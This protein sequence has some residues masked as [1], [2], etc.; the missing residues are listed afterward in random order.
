M[1]KLKAVS[2]LAALPSASIADRSIL[3][4]AAEVQDGVLA[5]AGDRAVGQRRV[6]EAVVAGAA[7]QRIA[8]PAAGE[9]VG[10]GHAPQGVGIGVS[11]QGVGEAE[12][13]TCSMPLSVSPAASPPETRPVARLTATPAAE[14]A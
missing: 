4:P 1:P 13:I 12:P 9:H 10:S 2:P 7:L 6:D 3:S 5:R 14:P 11:G 8:A